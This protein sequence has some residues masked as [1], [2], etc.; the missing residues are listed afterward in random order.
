MRD[1]LRSLSKFIRVSLVSGRDMKNVRD[2]VQLHQ[3]IYAGSHG[4]QIQGPDNLSFDKGEDFQKPLDNIQQEIEDVLDQ[5]IYKGSEIERK[6]SAIAVHYRN[7]DQG[8]RVGDMESELNKLLQNY[9][10]LK[11]DRGKMIFEIKPGIEWH[12][13]KAL[14]WIMDKLNLSEEKY[15]PVYIGDDTTDEDG[16]KAISDSGI[17]ILVGEHELISAAD[18]SLNDVDEVY[19]F[20]K[21]LKK[22]YQ[23]E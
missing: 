22:R 5:S 12:K 16:F 1:V 15:A 13:G 2:K 3:L 9:P 23:Y 17:S 20:L 19:E 6:S 18:Y 8:D 21:L 11:M 10:S 4:Y 7:L 14:E